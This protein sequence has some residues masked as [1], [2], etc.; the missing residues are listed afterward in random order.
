MILVIVAGEAWQ[1]EWPQTRTRADR[2][3]K[4]SR[5]VTYAH[6]PGQLLKGP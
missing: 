2:L 6:H 5:L 1:G 4:G 3:F